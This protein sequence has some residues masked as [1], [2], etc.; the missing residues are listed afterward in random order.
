MARCDQFLHDSVDLLYPG[1][2]TQRLTAAVAALA[3]V[4]LPA[5]ARAADPKEPEYDQA[6]IAASLEEAPGAGKKPQKAGEALEVPPPPPRKKGVVLET[7]LGMM[8]FLG[9]LKNISPTASLFH[10]QLGYEPFKWFMVFGEGDLGFTS[11]RYTSVPRG[12]AI[13]GA[14]AGGRITIGLSDRV[15]IYGQ[16][17][18]GM[19]EAST[20]DLVTYGFYDADSLNGYFGGGGGL[21]WYMPDPHMA[22][23]MNGGARKT[24]GFQRA[25]PGDAALSWLASVAL[26]YTF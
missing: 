16:V 24:Q 11:T 4:A 17:D 21:E 3:L 14:G 22:L 20:D 1:W 8:G 13:Y 6:A 26:R 5:I 9:K 10:L 12:Y 19:M 7:G 18:F 15:S 25:V 23:A 2:V